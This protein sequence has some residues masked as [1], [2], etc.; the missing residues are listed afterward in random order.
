MLQEEHQRKP[1]QYP[2]SNA[3]APRAVSQKKTF[4]FANKTRFF[5]VNLKKNVFFGLQQLAQQRL[6]M[7]TGLVFQTL[8]KILLWRQSCAT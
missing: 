3:V 1:D 2:L 7:D 5:F 4:F 6:T 8:A